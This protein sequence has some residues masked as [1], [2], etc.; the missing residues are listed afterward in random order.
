M[1]KIEHQFLKITIYFRF[2]CG[3]RKFCVKVKNSQNEL[4]FDCLPMQKN[5][6]GYHS[7]PIDLKLSLIYLKKFYYSKFPNAVSFEKI[8]AVFFRIEL[9]CIVQV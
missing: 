6:N 5:T 4:F 1:R 8:F 2:T 9:R 7:V 3:K